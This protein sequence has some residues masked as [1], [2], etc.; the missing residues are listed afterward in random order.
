MR[1]FICLYA[2]RLVAGKV[3]DK[4]LPMDASNVIY[5]LLPGGAFWTT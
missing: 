3:G 1:P 4:N 5:S 2:G